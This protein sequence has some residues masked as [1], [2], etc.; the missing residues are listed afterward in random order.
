MIKWSERLGYDAESRRKF[1][2]SNPGLA[3]GFASVGLE[4]GTGLQKV[5]ILA[6]VFLSTIVVGEMTSNVVHDH[7]VLDSLL[8]SGVLKF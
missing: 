6:T 4:L 8:Q 5:S 1:V 7:T 2:I 3:V